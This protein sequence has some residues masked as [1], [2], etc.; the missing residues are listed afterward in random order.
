MIS[1]EDLVR[2]RRRHETLV[3]RVAETRLPTRT[4]TSRR[5]A[6]GSP[7]TAPSTSRWCTATSPATEPVLTRVHSECLTGDVFG[8]HRCDCGPQLDEAL[9]RDRR[10]GPRRG[11][12]PARPRGPGHRP[13]R[14]AAGLPAP[15]RRP[16]HRR[17][18]PRPRPARRR[19]R[20][21]APPPR[22]CATSASASVRLLTNNPDKVTQPRGLRHRRSPSGCRSPRTPRPQPRLPAD[23][24]GPDGPRPAR[25]ATAPD[26]RHRPRREPHQ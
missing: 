5:T 26:L 8:S 17:R 9:E 23:Q 22:S 25:P 4:A 21:T 12:L 11:G 18:Q 2:Y 10:G 16:R 19:P 14:Q 1:I 3:E 24:A 20:T 6:T 15:G 7:S 13:G